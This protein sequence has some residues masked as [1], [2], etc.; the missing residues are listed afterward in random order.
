MMELHTL[1]RVLKPNDG[2]MGDSIPHD[3][4][5]QSLMMAFHLGRFWDTHVL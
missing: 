4:T 2:Q 1:K 3:G 5:N